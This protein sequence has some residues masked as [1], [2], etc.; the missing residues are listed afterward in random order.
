M[1]ETS[2]P[3]SAT[4]VRVGIVGC[5]SIC[6]HRHAPEYH[7]NPHVEIVSF[8]DPSRERA[9]K[10]VRLFGGRPASDYSEITRDPGIDAISDC[11]TNDAHHVISTDALE[12]GKHVL[13][14]KPM[15]TTLQ[16]ART[17]VEAG[18]KAGR[19]LMIGYNQRLA[20]GHRK[21]KEILRT[22]ELGRVITF[23]TTFGHRGPEH[24]SVNRSR[25]TWFFDAKRSVFGA[26]GD[27]GIH[28]ID[29]L[30]WL[31]EDEFVEVSSLAETLDK[32]QEDGKPIPVNDNFVCLLKTR[33][34]IVG[35]LTAS[36]TYYGAED[37]ATVLCCEKGIMRI[38][39][40]P[41][42]QVV[43]TR[44]DGEAAYYR[45]SQIQTNEAQVKSGVIDAF[46]DSIL[47]GSPPLATGEDGL[48]GLQV[49]VAAMESAAKKNAV[50][51]SY[52]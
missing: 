21:A 32:T 13:C 37:N 44:P 3:G 6:E 49:V 26:A 5:G 38:Y 27:L 16:D 30:R 50:R 24:W 8:F 28:K 7:A 29:L 14:E 1:K 19:I 47:T 43:V 11:S 12:H 51:I 48:R 22:G 4:K 33:T 46:I 17:M 20:G 23:T 9:E 2:R 36:W 52:D 41:A 40:D 18:R 15:A 39:A 42:Y 25:S 34:G 31:L 45:V 35:T 10:M